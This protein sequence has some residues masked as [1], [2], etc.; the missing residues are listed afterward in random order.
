MF[1]LYIAITSKCNFQCSH[2]ITSSSPKNG[3][4]RLNDNE[5]KSLANTVNE[6][7]EIECVHF[8]GGEP[9]ISMNEMR[10]L[11][12]RFSRKVDLAITTNGSLPKARWSELADLGLKYI[13]ISYDLFH[14]PFVDLNDLLEFGE[15][16]K[17]QGALVSFNIVF[18]DPKDLAIAVPIRESGFDVHFAKLV[19]GGAANKKEAEYFVS[20]LEEQ[21]CPSLHNRE[22]TSSGAEKIIYLPGEGF[23]WCC[24]PLAFTNKAPAELLSRDFSLETNRLYK[25]MKSS[26]NF[27]AIL[28][29]LKVKLTDLKFPSVCDLCSSI[30]QPIEALPGNSI[31]SLFQKQEDNFYIEYKGGSFSPVEEKII[32][33]KFRILRVLTL[34]IKESGKFEMRAQ[35][36]TIEVVDFNSNWIQ[37]SQAFTSKIFYQIHSDY[38][39][40]QERISEIEG[41]TDYFVKFGANGK[42]FLKDNVVVG[43]LLFNDYEVHPAI[44][45]RSRHIGFWGYDREVLSKDEANFIKHHWLATLKSGLEG[46][47]ILDCSIHTFNQSSLRFAEKVGFQQTL[48]RFERRSEP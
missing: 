46:T 33:E 39:T 26:T 23:T 36:K 9:T 35:N 19:H 47:R 14:R 16:F 20:N 24:G 48:W 8:S 44:G 2:C 1:E 28:N 41:L 13:S 42:V 21:G 12:K 29:Q 45:T 11:K 27:K 43:L 25:I 37:S 3:R 7:H 32:T 5:I 38:Y 10:D 22:S 6:N 15:F 18:S 17:V 31:A 34:N 4:W 30:F 40:E